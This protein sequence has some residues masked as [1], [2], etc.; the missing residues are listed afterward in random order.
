M[1]PY[2]AQ[3]SKERTTLGGRGEKWKNNMREALCKGVKQPANEGLNRSCIN[4][5]LVKQQ[6]TFEA[7][8]PSSSKKK[9]FPRKTISFLAFHIFHAAQAIASVIHGPPKP[10]F[11]IIIREDIGSAHIPINTDSLPTE[12]GKRAFKK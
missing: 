9:G 10:I 2:T 5:E 4:F 6:V 3:S 7:Y 12:L 8:H 11:A 1:T